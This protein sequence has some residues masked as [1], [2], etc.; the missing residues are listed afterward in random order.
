MERN[1]SILSTGAKER[2]QMVH[3]IFKFPSAG[4]RINDPTT[5]P[6][7]LLYERISKLLRK[8]HAPPRYG[9]VPPL[10]RGQA[11]RPYRSF[12]SSPIPSSSTDEPRP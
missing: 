9:V 5:R 3:N 4:S 10:K 6:I 8:L 1:F 12:P 2:I 7:L 11:P